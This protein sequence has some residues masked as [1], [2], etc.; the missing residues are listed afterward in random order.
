[1]N[2]FIDKVAKLLQRYYPDVP[3]YVSE[4]Y[5]PSKGKLSFNNLTHF[6]CHIEGNGFMSKALLAELPVNPLVALNLIALSLF[7]EF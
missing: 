5:V 7:L 4:K 2:G 6:S 1:M 3:K